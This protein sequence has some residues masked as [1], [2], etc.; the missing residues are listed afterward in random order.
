GGHTAAPR[1]HADEKRTQNNPRDERPR[2]VAMRFLRSGSRIEERA[3]LRGEAGLA[4][5][6]AVAVTAGPRLGAVQIAA[7]AARMRVLDLLENEM[8]FPVLAFLGQRGRA[9]THFNPLHAPV[10]QLTRLPHVARVF[11][12]GDRALAERALVY[13]ACE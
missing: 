12:A 7:P 6:G 13:G 10:V 4:A 9:V 3:A 8:L 11:V 1:T 2:P 5:G